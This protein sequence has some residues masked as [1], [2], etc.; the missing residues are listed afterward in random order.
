MQADTNLIIDNQSLNTGVFV[1]GL[2]K[3]AS[4]FLYKLFKDWSQQTNFTYF[5]SNLSSSQPEQLT[6]EINTNFCLCPC[7]HFDLH[8]EE[9]PNAS[10]IF[11][12][13]QIR[14]PRD[15]LVSQYFSFGWIHTDKD[16]DDAKKAE[17]ERIRNMEID[18]YVLL[19]E[20]DTRPYLLST[21]LNKL[22]SQLENKQQD[23][24]IL[25]KYE[26]MVTDLKQWLSKVIKP[27]G[28]ENESQV[29]NQTYDK[30]IHQFQVTEE[31]MTHR[32]KITPG[33]HLEKLKPETIEKLNSK[34]REVLNRFNYSI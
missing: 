19:D 1:Y 14:D 20:K 2:H 34:Y 23:K 12:I 32:R 22:L 6:Q 10:E 27:F 25:V 18:D 21:H 4:M 9:Y 28:F 13:L 7:R 3:S 33:D 29:I 8:Q 15:I 26:E 17:R 16:W 5:S 30:Y 24:I 11:H 31:T